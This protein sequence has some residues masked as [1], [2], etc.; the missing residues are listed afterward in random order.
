MSDD[1]SK[2]N[3][4]EADRNPVDPGRYGGRGYV[5]W[6]RMNVGYQVVAVLLVYGH[7]RVAAMTHGGGTCLP[8][9]DRCD[10]MQSTRRRG[11]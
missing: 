6:M 1:V 3:R 9:A 10:M 5:R 7:R 2:G 11:Q 8:M 4:G